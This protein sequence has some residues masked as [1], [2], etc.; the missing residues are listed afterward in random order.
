VA[1]G[2]G[3]FSGIVVWRS[4]DAKT[5]PRGGLLTI[6]ALLFDQAFIA[7]LMSSRLLFASK[8]VR[9]RPVG[10]IGADM[11]SGTSDFSSV[12]GSHRRKSSHGKKVV[13][14]ST[15]DQ[16]RSRCFPFARKFFLGEVRE[17]R[18]RLRQ[19]STVR[20]PAT[21]AL[22]QAKSGFARGLRVF[23]VVRTGRRN[24]KSF[25]SAEAGGEKILSSAL[26][27]YPDEGV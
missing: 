6:S 21:R 7:H 17:L 2:Q 8:I 24:G 1:S 13:L 5:A 18:V 4:D 12:L 9:S 16:A 11:P 3:S 23:C 22:Q 15:G 27:F 20:A 14:F 19:R 10:A 26:L 25:I